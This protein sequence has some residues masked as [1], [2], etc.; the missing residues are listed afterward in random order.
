MTSRWRSLRLSPRALIGL[1]LIVA[2]VGVA[3]WQSNRQEAVPYDPSDSSNT[4]LRALA[5]WFEEMGHPVEITARLRYTP[6]SDALIVLHPMPRP[7]SELT[8][9]RLHTWVEEGGSLVLVGPAARE[10]ALIDTF[11]VEQIAGQRPGFSISQRQPLLPTTEAEW[12]GP[13]TRSSLSA[14]GNSELLPVLVDTFNSPVVAI[15]PLGEGIVWH[16]TEDFALTNLNLRDE[17]IATLVPTMLRTVAPYAPVLILSGAMTFQTDL[18]MTVQR[19][20]YAD[21]IGWGLL[22]AAGILL[23]YLV[24]QGRRLG[25]PLKAVAGAHPRPAADY[26]HAMATL[27]RRARQRP[28]LIAHHRARLKTALARATGVDPDLADAAWAEALQRND[29]LPASTI[30]QAVDLLRAY[31]RE[32]DDAALIAIVRDTDALIETLPRGQAGQP[33]HRRA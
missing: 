30:T 11:G 27:Q 23:L 16:L 14:F 3:W 25:P 18:P 17:H 12:S 22:A 1:V 31:G 6:P 24:L 19:W 13:F 20:L 29:R 32:F 4:G 28:A 15:Q 8:A 10:T 33:A 26:V 9:Q 7:V 2:L 5:L 21:P